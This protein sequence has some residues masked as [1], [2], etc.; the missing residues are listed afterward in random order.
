MELLHQVAAGSNRWVDRPFVVW[1]TRWNASD[2]GVPVGL[3]KI[4]KRQSPF[5]LGVRIVWHDH[6]V[7]G[8]DPAIVGPARHEIANVH[9][10]V[11]GFTSD[12]Y[13][14]A[15][16]VLYFETV[17]T[18]ALHQN[19]QGAVIA[20]PLHAV[21]RQMAPPPAADNGWPEGR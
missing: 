7:H 10:Q 15:I 9:N 14:V 5:F 11:W 6:P 4:G 8:R 17:A 1:Q 20:G 12:R 19:S 21:A 3:V 13:P 16:S 2:L 18:A